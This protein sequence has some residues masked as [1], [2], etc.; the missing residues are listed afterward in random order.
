MRDAG[1]WLLRRRERDAIVS[2]PEKKVL[3]LRS[4]FGLEATV[5]TPAVAT[6]GA[7]FEIDAV[8]EPAG[9]TTNHYHREQEETFQVLDGTLEVFRNGDWHKVPAGE[10]LTVP[11]GA[12]HAFRNPSETPVRFLNTHRPALTFQEFLETVDRLI[13]AGKIKGPRNLRSGIYLSLAAVEQGTSVQVKPPQM[14]LRGLAF[15]GRRL[16]YRL[17]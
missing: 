17:E 11:R 10:S 1:P 7:Y 14:L 5:T 16:G 3:D 6:D 13:R 8:L 4:I 9:H 12:T 2:G 15:I